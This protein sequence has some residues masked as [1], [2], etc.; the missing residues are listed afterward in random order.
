MKINDK[1]FNELIHSHLPELE[2]IQRYGDEVDKCMVSAYKA[3]E[4]YINA[5]NSFVRKYKTN[6]FKCTS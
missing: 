6:L 3:K 5:V 4:K 1:R 2:N